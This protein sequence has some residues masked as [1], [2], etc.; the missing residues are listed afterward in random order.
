[1]L[2][3]NSWQELALEVLRAAR[4]GLSINDFTV[5]CQLAP[6]EI[7]KSYHDRIRAADKLL[8]EGVIFL[9]DGFMRISNQEPPA[10]L[11]NDLKQ[12]VAVAW[13][14]LSVID[15]SQKLGSKFD[16]LFNEEL[17]YEGEIAVMTE[18]HVRLDQSLHQRIH[19][20][21][22]VDDSAGFDIR[23]PSII[24]S[25]VN[26]LFEVKTTS[27][28]GEQFTFFIS[29]NE[30]RVGSLNDNWRLIGVVK[31]SNSF[32]ILGH[33]SFIQISSFLPVDRAE[34][35]LWESAKITIPRNSFIKHLP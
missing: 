22:Q 13:D 29:R 15:P 35:G 21:S 30:A 7:G 24:D 5:R 17:G 12:G 31:E 11:E 16:R 14:I 4:E 27:R 8:A 33:L 26:F 10:W 2:E 6:I 19:H 25:S 20:T 32:L 18:L 28:P 9:D 34:N 23:S 1:M 3:N